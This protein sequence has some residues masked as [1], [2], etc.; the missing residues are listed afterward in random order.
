MGMWYWTA[1][2]GISQKG[3]LFSLGPSFLIVLF[4]W[5]TARF[6]DN[7]PPVAA[8]QLQWKEW[9]EIKCHLTHKSMMHFNEMV[10]AWRSKQNYF[11]SKLL[12]QLGSMQHQTKWQYLRH[13]QQKCILLSSSG[14]FMGS[15]ISWV[16]LL[17]NHF[18]AIPNKLVCRMEL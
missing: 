6:S 18:K 2:M 4:F 5:E 12:F 1:G 7:L 15:G 8:E 17:G 13:W 9:F 14:S 11:P 16:I 3:N 10:F